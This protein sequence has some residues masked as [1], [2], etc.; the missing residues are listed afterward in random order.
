MR[1]IDP[2]GNVD[3]TPETYPRPIRDPARSSGTDRD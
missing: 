3:P 1:A 2:A